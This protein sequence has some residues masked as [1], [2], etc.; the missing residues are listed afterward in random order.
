MSATLADRADPRRRRAERF[1]YVG[2]DVD[3]A[4]GTWRGTYDLDGRTWDQPFV[5]RLLDEASLGARLGAADLRFERW[6]VEARGWL[7]AVPA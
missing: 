2:F 7:V 1:A 3:A 5:A 6:L 4:S